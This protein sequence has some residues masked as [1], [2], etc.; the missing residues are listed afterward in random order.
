M[1]SVNLKFELLLS[2]LLSA[3]L[4]PLVTPGQ[5]HVYRQNW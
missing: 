4:D 5:L 3:I 1:S 2:C